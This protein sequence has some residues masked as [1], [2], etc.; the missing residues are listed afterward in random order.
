MS[1]LST[2][3]CHGKVGLRV[4]TPHAD[5]LPARVEVDSRVQWRQFLARKI[6]GLLVIFIVRQCFGCSIGRR[7]IY[8]IEHLPALFLAC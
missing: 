6:T 2:L 7:V 5:A 1:L 3:Q 4:R 8:K